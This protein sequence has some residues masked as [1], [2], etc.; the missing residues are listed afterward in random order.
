S[1]REQL[2]ASIFAAWPRPFLHA[3]T[4]ACSHPDSGPPMP[5]RHIVLLLVTILTASCVS[6]HREPADTES[7][8]A[9]VASRNGGTF[10]VEA[11]I[12]LAL[13]QNPRLRAL[14]ALV[15]AADANTIVPVT[16]RTEWR[17]R[18]DAI[19]AVIDPI[20]LLGLGPR[21]AAIDAADARLTEAVRSE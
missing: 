10:S 20:A 14:T 6:Y 8:A 13:Q 5:A 9:I 17:E 16:L 4:I 15:R 1:R 19:E 21:G 3:S 11:A 18:M 12:E 2:A 7:T